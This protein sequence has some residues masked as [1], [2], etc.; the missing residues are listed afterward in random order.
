MSTDK[1]KL[2]MIK[3]LFRNDTYLTQSEKHLC[4]LL[5]IRVSNRATMEWE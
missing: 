2:T 1:Q 4:I 5:F 3:D